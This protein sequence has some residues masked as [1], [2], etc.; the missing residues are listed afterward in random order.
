MRPSAAS[1]ESVGLALIVPPTIDKT[2]TLK[3]G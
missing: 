3:Y 1:P 2:L